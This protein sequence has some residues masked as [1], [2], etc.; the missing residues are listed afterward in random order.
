MA[1][2]KRAMALLAK[3]VFAPNAFD[4]DSP[5]FPYL[6]PQR[7]GFN[8]NT[9]GDDY[10]ITTGVLNNQMSAIAHVLNAATLQRITNS[11]LYG[12]QYTAADIMNDL[13]KAVFDVDFKGNVNVYRQYLQTTF[14]QITASILDPKYPGYDDVAKAASLYALKKIKTGLATAVSTNEETKA[15]RANLLFLINNA[16]ENK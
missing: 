1:T 12:N 16:L 9:A 8:Q 6:Q 3:Y 13:V 10:R 14:V 11:R 4:V 7:R 2:Q 15:H 5:V